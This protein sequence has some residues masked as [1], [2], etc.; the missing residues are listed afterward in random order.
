M[1]GFGTPGR[2]GG[3]GSLSVGCAVGGR[4]EPV[5]SEGPPD[6]VGGSTRCSGRLPPACFQSLLPA[7]GRPR[8]PEQL[9]EVIGRR[10]AAV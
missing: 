2:E 4:A 10:S 1:L 5:C 7:H 9:G 6:A 8:G 3:R